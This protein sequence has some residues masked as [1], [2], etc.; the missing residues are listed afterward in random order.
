M[1]HHLHSHSHK[2]DIDL[3]AIFQVK[4]KLNNLHDDK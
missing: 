4:I 2:I 3:P 1:I